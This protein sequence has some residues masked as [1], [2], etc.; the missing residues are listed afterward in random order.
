MNLIALTFDLV[1]KNDWMWTS[2]Q[3]LHVTA[4]PRRPH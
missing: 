1:S 2:Q 3:T 4:I